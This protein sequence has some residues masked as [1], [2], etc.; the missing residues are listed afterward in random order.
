MIY[1]SKYK[2]FIIEDV[3]YRWNIPKPRGG[4]GYTMDKIH[5]YLKS[6]SSSDTRRE[7]KI[8]EDYSQSRMLKR[9][10][11]VFN[12]PEELADHMYFHGTGGYVSGG[13][14][15]GSTFNE[16]HPRSGGYDQIQHS[17]SL[18]KNK[19]QAS[20]FSGISRSGIVYPV[21]LKKDSKIISMPDISDATEL[22]D[23]LPDLW[24]KGIDG[25]KIGNWGDWASEQEL[26]VLNPY[27]LLKMGGE[28]FSVFHKKKFEQPMEEIKNLYDSIKN[29][30]TELKNNI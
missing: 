19:N 20:N 23:I 25:V 9:F 12:S 30:N 13:L 10:V 27:C 1:L 7:L 2:D 29:P 26:V 18:S 24:S 8:G 5:K 11:S 16:K 4:T 14:K 17:V 28:H 15:A 6:L 21:I 3:S 22:E